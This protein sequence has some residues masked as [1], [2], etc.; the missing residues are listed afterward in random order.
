ME[1]KH[2][3]SI[4]DFS[5]EEIFRILDLAEGFEKIRIKTF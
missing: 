3:V 4:T 2:L 5:K 1:N